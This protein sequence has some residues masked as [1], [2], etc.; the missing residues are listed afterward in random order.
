MTPR[1]HRAWASCFAQNGLA[2]VLHAGSSRLW[3]Y[4]GGGG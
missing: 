3:D 4:V 1:F 2:A